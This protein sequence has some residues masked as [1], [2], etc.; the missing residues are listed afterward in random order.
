MNTVNIVSVSSFILVVATS[1]DTSV[2]AFPSVDKSNCKYEQIMHVVWRSPRPPPA[3]PPRARRAWPR[4]TRVTRVWCAASAS[5]APGKLPRHEC[6]VWCQL[7]GQG[8]VRPVQIL[9]PGGGGLQAEMLPGKTAETVQNMP[10]KLPLPLDWWNKLITIH[11][12]V[13]TRLMDCMLQRDWT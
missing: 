10:E 6:H 8:S 2:H 5:A 13:L 4:V 11:L 3:T 7:T 1:L 12:T 9:R